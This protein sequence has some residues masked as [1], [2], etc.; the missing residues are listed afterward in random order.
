M[1]NR[2]TFYCFVLALIVLDAVLL[3]SPNLLGKIGLIIYKYSYLRTFPKALLTISIVVGI[4]VVVAEAIRGLVSGGKMKRGTGLFFLIIFLSASIGLLVKTGI[5]FTAWSYAHT[6]YRFRFGAYLLPSIW[7]VIFA[8]HLFSLP[9]PVSPWPES[10]SMDR[11][12]GT[13]N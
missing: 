8:Y 10:P 1:K 13:E 12:D 5:D 9:T 7:V 2:L 4:A 11:T 3:R 6:G